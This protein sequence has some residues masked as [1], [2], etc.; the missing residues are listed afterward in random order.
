MTVSK[1]VALRQAKLICTIG[2]ASAGRIRELIEAGMDVARINFSYGN[3]ESWKRTVDDIRF[4]SEQL[5]RE[6]GIL[7]DLSGPKVRLGELAGGE[8][9]LVEGSQF[10][11][12]PESIV[13]D[14]SR[15]STTYPGLVDDLQPGDPIFLA[16]GSVELKVVTASETLIS[17]VVRRGVIR[18]GSGLNV[19]A[20]RLSLSALSSKDAADVKCG[21]DLGIDFFGQSFVRRRADVDDL[22]IL[23]GARR[24]P[25]VAKIETRP[26]VDAC[27]D[28]AAAADAIMVARGDLGVEIPL[29]SVPVAQKML[30]RTARSNSIPA[31]VATQML[32]SMTS[33][34]R[35]T[36]AEVSDVANAVL[37]GASAILLSAETAIGK[38]PVQAAMAAVRIVK[39]VETDGR[40]FA[41]A[42]EA[43]GDESDA[44]AVAI[45]AASASRQN[46]RIAAIVCYTQSGLTARL[47]SAALPPV[48]VFALSSDSAVVRQLTLWHDIAPFHTVL[49]KDTEA[50]I[51]MLDRYIVDNEIL[52]RG[53]TVVLVASTP[54]GKATTNLLKI[55]ELGS[56]K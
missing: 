11:I 24:V 53:R 7:G 18:D 37:D 40:Q 21:L 17:E 27:R 4:A 3:P 42:A 16:D 8:A 13:G 25:I 6:V 10:E 31:I 15:A 22:K 12:V 28:I 9:R 39:S 34:A 44:A 47:L 49:P 43:V 36:R 38:F 35:P 54:V 23:I 51:A 32:E 30:V 1:K 29:E 55:H 20:A 41:P 26:A 2:P 52:T 33:S 50:I 5:G 56:W 46:P 14:A 19:P 48:P 45:A